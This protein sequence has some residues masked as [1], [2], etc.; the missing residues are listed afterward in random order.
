MNEEQL[1][2]MA[3]ELFGLAGYYLLALDSVWKE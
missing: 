2:K 1:V 3:N